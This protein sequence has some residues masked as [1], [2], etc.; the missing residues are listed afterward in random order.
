MKL[1]IPPAHKVSR[2]MYCQDPSNQSQIKKG[3]YH[4]EDTPLGMEFG[5]ADAPEIQFFDIRTMQRNVGM[6][7]PEKN[8]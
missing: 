7:F 2:T 8:P 1:V 6:R 4:Y 3:R 5:K